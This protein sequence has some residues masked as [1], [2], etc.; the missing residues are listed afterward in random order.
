MRGDAAAAGLFVL[1]KVPL[2]GGFLRARLTM[3]FAYTIA[4]ACGRHI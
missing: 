2:A 4:R 3:H 1:A